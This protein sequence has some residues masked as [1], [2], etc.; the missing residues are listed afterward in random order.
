[1]QNQVIQQLTDATSK[2]YSVMKSLGDINSRA[3]SKMADL[4]FDIISVNLETGLDQSKLLFSKNNIKDAFTDSSEL[5]SDYSEKMVGFTRQTLEIFADTRDKATNL[6]EN[7]IVSESVTE[8][9]PAKASDATAAKSTAKKPAK[10][11]A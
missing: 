5:A 6:L 2:S 10:T 9:K 11:S 4:Q 1:M 3:L 8:K 7:I